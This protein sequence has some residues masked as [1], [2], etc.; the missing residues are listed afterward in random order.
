MNEA[1]LPL[2]GRRILLTRPVGQNEALADAIRAAGGEPLIFPTLEIRDLDDDAA[3]AAATAVLHEYDLAVFVSPNAVARALPFILARR[4]WP[5]ELRAATVG[6]ATAAALRAH[7]VMDVLAPAEQFDSEHLLALLPAD[8]TGWRVAIFRGQQGRPFLADNL[9]S[10]G[11]QVDFV[12]CY[13]RERPSTAQSLEGPIDA[14]VLTSSEGV[15]NLWD[16]LDPAGRALLRRAVVFVPHA[17]IAAGARAIGLT[18][19]V[20]TEPGDAGLLAALRAYWADAAPAA[21]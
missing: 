5:A 12:P 21:S 14:C 15:R 13:R 20:Q 6:P 3:L 11:A 18:Q 9:R 7:G 4:V 19:V 8:L 10:R 1:E 16:M 17:R 2:V